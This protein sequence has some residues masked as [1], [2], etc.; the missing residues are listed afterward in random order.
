MGVVGWLTNKT[1]RNG[2]TRLTK[3]LET[4]GPADES[5]KIEKNYSVERGGANDVDLRIAGK[6]RRI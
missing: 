5:L 6:L 4:Q 3:C 1:G 2:N